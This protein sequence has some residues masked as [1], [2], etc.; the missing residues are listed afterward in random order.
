MVVIFTVTL[1]GKP[2]SF[3]EKLSW[4]VGSPDFQKKLWNPISPKMTQ[5]VFHKQAGQAPALVGFGHGNLID[6]SLVSSQ[7]KDHKG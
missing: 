4:S 2:L 5:A 1:Q 7:A 3:I 6:L